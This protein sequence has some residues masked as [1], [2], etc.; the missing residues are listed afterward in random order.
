MV[1]TSWG[2]KEVMDVSE[3]I[4]VFW[5]FF[6]VVVISSLLRGLVVFVQSRLYCPRLSCNLEDKDGLRMEASRGRDKASYH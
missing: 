3:W 1:A 2:S 4:G 5:C 6:I